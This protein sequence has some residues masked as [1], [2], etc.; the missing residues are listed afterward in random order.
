MRHEFFDT[1]LNNKE[2]VDYVIQIY[3]KLILIL[4]YLPHNHEIQKQFNNQFARTII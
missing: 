2:S 1:V 3:Q 4:N